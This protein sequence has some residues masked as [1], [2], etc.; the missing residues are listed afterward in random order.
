MSPPTATS[1]EGIYS[2]VCSDV[3]AEDEKKK[4]MQPSKAVHS[5]TPAVE[6]SS[7]PEPVPVD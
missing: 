7:Q 2:Y 3:E 5:S 6:L 1:E 4:K